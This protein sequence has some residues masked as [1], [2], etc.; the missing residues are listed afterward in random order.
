MLREK[1]RNECSCF[2]CEIDLTCCKNSLSRLQAVKIKRLMTYNFFVSYTI[3]VI[4][5]YLNVLCQARKWHNEIYHMVQITTN[6]AFFS[7]NIVQK[8]AWLFICMILCKRWI[9]I[10]KY[11]QKCI[12]ECKTNIIHTRFRL[13]IFYDKLGHH[14]T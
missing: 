6:W 7:I 12:Y 3:A 10:S 13:N 1:D 2:R 11:F 4:N 8:F 14:S 9:W 5:C